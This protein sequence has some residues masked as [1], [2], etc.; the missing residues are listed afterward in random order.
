MVKKI[1]IVKA[2]VRFKNKYLLLKKFKD[3]FFQENIGKWE[4]PGGQITKDE[5]PKKTILREVKEETGLD[6]RIIKELPS[7]RMTD[8]NYDSHCKIYLLEA[9]SSK[10]MLSPEHSKYKWLYSQK[11]KNTSLVL[12][13]S[14]LL[15]Y[16][17]N[18]EKYLN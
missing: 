18:P 13:A 10:V 7:L 6:C 5:D 4:C 12:Y 14:L 11:I 15:E 16:F 9:P 3:A 8:K 2:L 17:N 1:R